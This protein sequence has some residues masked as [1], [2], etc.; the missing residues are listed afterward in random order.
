MRTINV[1]ALCAVLGC[2]TATRAQSDLQ[3]ELKDLDIAAHWIYDD[4]PKGLAQAKADS[5]PLLVV[6]RCVP[7]PPGK[8]LDGKVMQPDKDIEELEKK[9]V[10]VRVIQ[11][12]GLDLKLFQYDYDQSWAAFFLNADGTIYGRYGTRGG[13]GPESDAHLTL[14]SFKKAAER[15]LEIHKKYPENKEE[16]ADKIGKAPDYKVPEVIPGLDERSKGSPTTRQTCIHCHMVREYALRAKWKDKKLTAADLWVYPLP[17]S[18]G[19]TMDTDDGLRIK[20]VAAD[21]PAAKAGLKAGDELMQ[22]AGQRL[23]SEADIQ[24]VLHNSANDAKLRVAFAH[25]G[26]LVTATI[27]VAG[28]W[29]EGDIA[30]RASSWYGLRQGLKVDPLTADEKKKR[31]LGEDDLGLVIKGLFG[32]GGQALTKAGLKQNDVIVAIDGKTAA[33]T[34]SQFLAALRLQHGP[35]D[36]VKLTILRGEQRMEIQV[37]MW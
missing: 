26:K 4:L 37:P 14:A 15:A 9:F 24:W 8:D 20:A 23:I 17:S 11:T 21:S 35:D 10:C 2:V 3:R 29:K 30:W 16:L 19:L 33:L 5:K 28:N 22:L 6:L 18:I 27:E 7:C 36:S 12:K 34:E 1:V 25:E 31:S 32:T 13:R